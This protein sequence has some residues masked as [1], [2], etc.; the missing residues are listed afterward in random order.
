MWVTAIVVVSIRIQIWIFAKLLHSYCTKKYIDVE[1]K[2]LTFN[3]SISSQLLSYL[4]FVSHPVDVLDTRQVYG[5]DFGVSVDCARAYIL[6]A[7]IVHYSEFINLWT[8]N[9]HSNFYSYRQFSLSLHLD[10]FRPSR[11]LRVAQKSRHQR[12]MVAL[13]RRPAGHPAARIRQRT[14][15]PAGAARRHWHGVADR[16]AAV[17]FGAAGF[18]HCR[19]VQMGGAQV[20]C[21]ETAQWFCSIIMMYAPNCRV[22][23]RAQRRAR[24]DFGTKLGMN[25]PFWMLPT[26]FSVC[27]RDFL[28]VPSQSR[29][30]RLSVIVCP[31]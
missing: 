10:Q 19:D 7:V 31:A 28:S 6:L 21:N 26:Q 11:L 5:D 20:S 17:R 12:R 15:S 9:D 14:V 3:Y 16:C 30:C 24:L 2:C 4:T 13:R 1:Y 29:C 23:A 25:S 22:N 27:T 8:N 18:R